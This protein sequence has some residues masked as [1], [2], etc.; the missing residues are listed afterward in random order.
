MDYGSVIVSSE[1]HIHTHWTDQLLCL[2]HQTA[3][4]ESTS[5]LWHSNSYH[6]YSM[7]T[8]INTWLY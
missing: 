7:R 1:R 8:G 2:D 5:L 3:M 6:I 4:T